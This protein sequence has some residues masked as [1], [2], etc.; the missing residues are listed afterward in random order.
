MVFSWAG[1]CGRVRT[2]LRRWWSEDEKRGGSVFRIRIFATR[3]G[4]GRGLLLGVRVCGSG[5]V[6]RGASERSLRGENLPQG[7]EAPFLFPG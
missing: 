4:A 5:V 7:L 6:A 2:M 1:F 3:G